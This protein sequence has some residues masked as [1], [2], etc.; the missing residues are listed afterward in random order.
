ME[1]ENLKERPKDSLILQLL[2]GE[3]QVELIRKYKELFEK[4]NIRISQVLLTHHNFSSKKERKT[5]IRI[6]NAYLKKGIIP[7]INENDLVNK[8]ELEKNKI[9]TDNDILSAIIS[10]SMKTD[11][12]I[13]L[14]DVDGLYDSNPNENKQAKLIEQVKEITQETKQL[15][16][17]KSNLGLGGMLS[18]IIAAEIMNKQGIDVIVGNGNYNIINLIENKVNRTLFK[19][20]NL[21]IT[22]I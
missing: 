3:G 13:I 20:N 16:K 8:E 7:I 14:T 4:E 5:I 2:S 18:K 10:I 9:F 6:L 19:S 17:G 1:I 15:A 12:T 11:L 21:N 22:K